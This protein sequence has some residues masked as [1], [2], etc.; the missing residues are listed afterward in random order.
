MP[1]TSRLAELAIPLERSRF[2]LLVGANPNYF[3][4]LEAS[5]LPIV[6]A[7]SRQ[8]N[9]E[10]LMCVGLQPE[11]SQLEAVVHLKQGAGYSGSLCS[12]GSPE[13]VRFFVSY[14]DGATWH[15]EGLSQFSAHDVAGP[16]PLEFAVSRPVQLNARLCFIENLVR[17]RAILSWNV[18]PTAGNS[19]FTPVWGNVVEAVVQV[20]PRRRIGWP[21]LVEASKLVLPSEI[22]NLLHE[23]QDLLVKAPVELQVAELHGLYA[24]TDVPAHRYL[25]KSLEGA[26]LASS[27]IAPAME[28]GPKSVFEVESGLAALKLDPAKLIND[29]IKTNGDTRFEQLTCIGFD[30]NN[31]ALVGVVDVKLSSG[32]S[33]GLCTAGSREY[34]AFWI[35][36]NDGAG[37]Q[38]AGTTSF[39]SHDITAM[40]ADGL[41]YAVFEVANVGAHRRPCQDGPVLAKVRAILSWQSVPPAGNPD[42]VPT[43]GNRQETEILIEATAAADYQ[44]IF[45]SVGGVPVCG[46]DPVTGRTPGSYDQPFG[47]AITITGFIPSAPDLATPEASL[48]RYRVQVRKQGALA[49]ETITS[50]FWISII[51]RIG[52]NMPVQYPKLQEIGSDGYFTYRED[53]NGSGAGWRLVQNRVLATWITAAPLTGV[54]D[55]RL[56]AKDPVTGMVYAGQSLACPD[57]STRTI[58]T[59]ELDEV[60]PDCDL[61][62]TGYTHAGGPLQVAMDCDTF[63]VGDVIHGSYHVIDEHAGGFTLTVEPGGP[64]HGAHTNP[65]GKTY[66]VIPTLGEAGAWSLDTTGM[67]AC[68][69]IV[70]IWSWDR[71]IVSG[72]SSGWKCAKSVGFCLNR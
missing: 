53:M 45:E 66:P 1:R 31:D 24:K 57:G 22:A 10:E 11:T 17:V 62:I 69:Y 29:I 58:V 6:K 48:L 23:K 30:P 26:A 19:A 55:I 16:K 9:Y 54:Y 46:I 60:A 52:L 15:D 25:F 47:G 44:P 65:A 42:W 59:I 12:G 41:K 3:G 18:A 63:R 37:W 34:V 71:T 61:A 40:P 43:W 64:A 49:W 56:E 39:V 5:K 14:D 7:L 67:D 27:F 2:H 28:V 50:S 8:T 38:H 32:Y 35:D 36:W 20:A 13:Y 72:D 4:T 68:G 70:R 51:E 33:G 21:E